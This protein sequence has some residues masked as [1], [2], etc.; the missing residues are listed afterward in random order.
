MLLFPV[1]GFLYQE[2][3]FGKILIIYLIITMISL[4]FMNKYINEMKISE[5][6][7]KIEELKVK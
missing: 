5:N 2:I 3:A 6:A 7:K 1:T 4:V